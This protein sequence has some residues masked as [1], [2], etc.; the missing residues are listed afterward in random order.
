MKFTATPCLLITIS[1]LLPG[2]PTFCFAEVQEIVATQDTTILSNPSN[3]SNGSGD[4]F[5]VGRVDDTGN[6]SLRRALIFF[7]IAGNIP[8]GSTIMSATLKLRMSKTP[9]ALES[10]RVFLHRLKSDWGEGESD[11]PEEEGEGILAEQND[12]TWI[13]RIFATDKW[14]EEGGD[15]FEDA[16]A[17][18]RIGFPGV[19]TWGTTTE[20][21]AD[22]QDWLDNPETNSGWIL[23]GDESV[24][25]S[26]KRFD[27][28]DNSGTAQ[29]PT[30]TIEFLGPDCSIT[31]LSVGDRTVCSTDTNTY[32]QEI[33][34]AYNEEPETGF[35]I[36]N[37]QQ[38]PII[39]SPQTVEL[40][41]LPA[42]G[43][44][45]D[46]SA[47]FSNSPG[48]SSTATALFTAPD[49]CECEIESITLS[50]RSIC[51]PNTNSF[52]QRLRV[53]YENPPESGTLDINGQ[54]FPVDRSP[55]TITLEDLIA[56]GSNVDVT[57]RF[58]ENASCSFAELSFF[59][60]PEPCSPCT[61]IQIDVDV[62]SECD[63][64][65]NTYSQALTLQYEGEPTS[66]TL[67]INGRSFPI[68]QSPQSIS[69]ENLLADG[70]EVDVTARFSDRS[71]CTLTEQS[72]FTAPD[73][74]PLC[75][76][77]N[78]VA[79]GQPTCNLV[80]NTYSQDVTFFIETLQTFRE[81]NVN[82]IPF[83]LE[84]S[85]QTVTLDGL[86][87]DNSPVDITAWFT[88]TTILSDG[89]SGESTEDWEGSG[90]SPPLIIADGGPN[91]AGDGYLQVTSIGG[92]GPGSHLAVFNSAQWAV[93]YITMGITAIAVDLN[94]IGDTL[95][96]IRLLLKGNG[97]EFVSLKS[98]MLKSKSGWQS[99][100]FSI[101][102]NDWLKLSGDTSIEQALS[103]VTQLQIFHNPEAN[104]PGPNIV[105]ALGF[106]N[107]RG[108][109]ALTRR[110]V[111]I[112]PD[113]TP[114]LSLVNGWNLI[115]LPVRPNIPSIDTIFA[116]DNDGGETVL[117]SPVWTWKNGRFMAINELGALTGYWVHINGPRMIRVEGSKPEN[118][119]GDIQPGWNLVGPASDNFLLPENG[120]TDDR[121]WGSDGLKLQAETTLRAMKGYW[122]FSGGQTN[123]RATD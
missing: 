74:C 7:D 105:S 68:N 63:R 6:F 101:E 28:K 85:S 88:D 34:V 18:E 51:N 33:R 97:G 121:A 48:C 64:I 102:G 12:A 79:N 13:H 110:Q 111:F 59:T 77:T 95:L 52:S 53:V 27:S 100:I 36:V 73:P 62:Q 37:N 75:E 81:L 83:Q 35:L 86:P 42:D 119:D 15:F 99:L 118:S 109:C 67:D 19:Y 58:S 47:Q 25:R 55:Q 82:G 4:Y 115:S 16:S 2:I 50:T 116:D 103:N 32:N 5:F 69:L 23:I 123:L 94:N 29:K 112:A 8:M 76:I 80:S 114:I 9:S 90:P 91:G 108:V 106:D 60:A 98:E 20:M 54:S 70:L 71:E 122:L 11:A 46:I 1:F 107:I 92:E 38:F 113:C 87:A 31:N 104:F 61:I 65:T 93:D 49:S 56:D 44:N 78:I 45:V 21:V 66:G 3:F 17:N 14:A 41:G 120:I 72:L 24:N 30:L 96:Q 39:T 10:H 117:T 89:F 43:E 84:T 57:A 22:I 40:V 26:A